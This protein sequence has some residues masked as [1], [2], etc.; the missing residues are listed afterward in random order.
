MDGLVLH[1]P[2]WFYA[3][4]GLSQGLLLWLAGEYWPGQRLWQALCSGGLMLVLVGCWQLQMMFGTLR[5][6]WPWL[7]FN[8]LLVA[9]L[10]AGLSWQ[11]DGWRLL[12]FRDPGG[13]WLFFGNL[14]IAFVLTAFIQA[15]DVATG[16]RFDYLALCRHAWNNG[17]ALFLA[18]LMLAGFW[19]LIMLWAMLF[20]TMGVDFFANFFQTRGFGWGASALI[21][22]IALRISLERG[23]IL[24]A[25]RNVIQAMCR[26]LL[27][28]TVLILLLFASS[29]PLLGLEPLWQTRT[30]CS[31]LL[32]L[33]IAHLWLVNGVFQDGGRASGYPRWLRLLVNLSSLTL[34]LLAGLAAYALWLRIAQYGLTPERVLGVLPVLLANLY[35]WA[36]AWA[37]LAPGEL[38]LGSLRR[39][40]PWLALIC[41]GLIALLQLGPLNPL[42]LS[43]ASQYQRL[44][45]GLPEDEQRDLVFLLHYRWG[46]PGREALERLRV[47]LPELDAERRAQL[48]ELLAGLDAATDEQAWRAQQP[49]FRVNWIGEVLIS[50]PRELEDLLQREYGCR[51]SRCTLWSQDVD[52]DGRLELVLINPQQDRDYLLFA[53]DEQG[54][55]Q[56]GRLAGP[57]K[58]QDL[59]KQLEAGAS[60]QWVPARVR[61]LQIGDVRLEPSSS[62]Y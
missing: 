57:L 53:R 50:D 54:W 58:P 3:L 43:A 23:G 55:Q 27:P 36:L 56:L 49:V 39:S 60:V 8:A 11:F 4:L 30:A 24:D 32:S 34:P 59:L 25:L 14:L 28:L 44:L 1:R 41:V 31:I 48:Q 20:E 6:R 13:A 9:A 15:R 29:L 45:S 12:R 38:W 62:R 35:A 26:F 37:V 47:E 16:R 2:L 40:N 19:L 7:L 42:Q 17:L 5:Q 18:G 21:C 61:A 22:S 46:E 10:S 33:V 52:G 51:H